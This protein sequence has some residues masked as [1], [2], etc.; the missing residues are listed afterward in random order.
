MT[1]ANSDLRKQTV[2]IVDDVPGNIDVLRGIL[3][4]EYQ[5][6]VATN[7]ELAL[8]IATGSPLPDLI[9]LDIMMPVMDGYQVCQSLKADYR[10][11][12]IPV[13]FVTAMGEVRDEARG[14]EVGGVDYI[15]K[16]VSPP[17]VLARVRTQLAL[18]DQ[19]RELAAQ[20]RERTAQLHSTRL[21]I[22]Q[23]LGR[24]AEYKD[25]DTGLHVVRMSHYSKI[26]ALA[27][28]MNGDDAELVFN[29]APMHDIG[30]I[31]IPDRILQKPA[32]LE[33]SEWSVMRQHPEI[34]AEIIGRNAGD[35]P[36]LALACTIALTHHEKWDGSG[37]PH[38]IEGEAIPVEGRIVALADVFDALTS[39]R[40]YKQAWPVDKALE[41]IASESG[42]HFDPRVVSAMQSA[43]PRM[44]EIKE[45]HGNPGDGTAPAAEKV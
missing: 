15:T 32:K 22:I 44:L 16:P 26:V 20:V 23:T 45:S 12:R 17:I 37:Y 42:R 36:L 9:L 14:F 6:K 29:A 38:G 21:Q 4:D 1:T 27:M 13:I 8:K 31:G 34:G 30:K 35:S 24:A 10:T 11:R 25:E 3:R 43:M 40:P 33:A 18:Y 41:L 28:G 5:V 39:T 19:R 2:L 7:G